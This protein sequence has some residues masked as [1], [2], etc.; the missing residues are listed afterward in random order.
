MLKGISPFTP[1]KNHLHHL[2]IDL[3]FSHI[4]TTL[5]VIL[6]NLFVIGMWFLSYCLGASVDVQ[7]YIVIALGT[8]VT[9]VF[10]RFARRQEKKQS[11]IYFWMTRI[12][13]STHVNQHKWFK[14]FTDVLDRNCDVESKK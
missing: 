14:R 5:A 3:H 6:I 10:N 13:D 2:L 4:G 7:L 9:F 1:D 8:L 12:G 11:K